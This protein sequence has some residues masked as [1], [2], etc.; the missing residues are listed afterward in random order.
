VLLTSKPP[1]L[2]CVFYR[3]VVEVAYMLMDE[4]SRVVAQFYRNILCFE[5][6]FTGTFEEKNKEIF[7]RIVVL[8]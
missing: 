2:L 3:V 1:I 5:T 7:T 6:N 8:R 4:L